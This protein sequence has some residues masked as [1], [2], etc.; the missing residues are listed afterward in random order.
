MRTSRSRPSDRATARIEP[1]AVKRTTDRPKTQAGSPELRVHRGEFRPPSR[2]AG[3]RRRTGSTSRSSETKWR[4]PAG[5]QPG[6]VDG[7]AG[8]AGHVPGLTQGATGRRSSDPQARRRPR[9]CRGDPTPARRG[10]AVRRRARRGNEVRPL[11]EH[12]DGAALPSSGIATIS[13]TDGRR[14]RSTLVRLADGVRAVGRA[15]S[16]RRSAYRHGP[17]GVIGTG[18]APSGVEARAGRRAI[19]DATMPPAID[20][21]EPPPYSWTRLRTLNRRRR[22][23]VSRRRPAPCRISVCRPPSAGRPSSQ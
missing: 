6:C 14:R 23:L 10:A 12:A 20:R 9:A 13:L 4:T 19:E 18:A 21:Y 8:P 11:D 3:P 22:Q 2:P 7:L 15:G 1:S 17:S 5:D 16:K